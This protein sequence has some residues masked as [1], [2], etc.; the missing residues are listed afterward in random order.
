LVTSPDEQCADLAAVWREEI[1]AMPVAEIADENAVLWLWTTNAH[2]RVAF[3]VVEAWSF[4][5]IT[6]P[7]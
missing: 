6:R 2:R 5:Q 3:D 4:G 1:K 7:P